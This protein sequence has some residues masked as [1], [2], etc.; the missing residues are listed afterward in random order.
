M[1]TS[2]GNEENYVILFV[3][4]H[5]SEKDTMKKQLQFLEFIIRDGLC[6]IR[7]DCQN[8][9]GYDPVS[10]PEGPAQRPK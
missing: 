8:H 7:K 4:S 6:V 1:K 3:K 10:T 5:I 9:I 2:Q